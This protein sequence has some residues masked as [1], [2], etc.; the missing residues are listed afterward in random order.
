MY[1]DRTG[2]RVTLPRTDPSLAD[3]T[4]A[5]RDSQAAVALTLSFDENFRS[6]GCL[7]LA[8]VM[9]VPLS[10]EQSLVAISVCQQVLGEEG[11]ASDLFLARCCRG[12]VPPKTEHF[13]GTVLSGEPAS[14]AADRWFVVRIVQAIK[15]HGPC[16]QLFSFVLASFERALR[17]SGF[18]L[19]NPRG[20]VLTLLGKVVPQ[21]TSS[22]KRATPSLFKCVA[23]GNMLAAWRIARSFCPWPFRL[24]ATPS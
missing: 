17:S 14:D 19:L 21:K 2:G 22:G 6:S 1:N 12:H 8:D 9:Y 5:T 13:D 16:V 20:S 24:K 4:K 18:P 15:R 11:S 3:L 10:Q 23:A 7:L